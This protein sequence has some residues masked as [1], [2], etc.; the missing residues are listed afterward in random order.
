MSTAA[1]A[2]RAIDNLAGKARQTFNAT[3]I[4][5]YVRAIQQ[6][7]Q[8]GLRESL[9]NQAKLAAFDGLLA[10]VQKIADDE[11]DDSC[12]LY[13]IEPDKC[14]CYVDEARHLVAKANE[15]QQPLICKESSLLEWGCHLIAKA[16]EQ[17][18]PGTEAPRA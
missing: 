6:L 15:V 4:R 12:D 3:V 5:D 17:T 14:T 16:K 10:F 11:H 2:F 1:E 9:A 7:A 18:A 13:A 8:N